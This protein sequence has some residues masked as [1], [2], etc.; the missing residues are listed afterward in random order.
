MEIIEQASNE[1]IF[2]REIYW[3]AYHRSIG[4][5]LTNNSDGGEGPIGY[6]HTEETVQKMREN[7]RSNPDNVK[8][9][10]SPESRRKA[11]LT[12]T[13]RHDSDQVR[14][15][16]SAGKMGIKASE[17]AKQHQ[18]AAAIKKYQTETGIEQRLTYGRNYA[19]LTDDQ[20]VEMRRLFR[21]TKLTHREISE[22][23]N[24]ALSTVS[25]IRHGKRYMHVK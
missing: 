6:K 4:T 22:M 21:E 5:R 10:H 9:L 16:K 14:R 25:H 24:I 20:V 19:K 2:E 8:R 1:V 12:R 18:S 11:S 17:S 7:A 13:G 15:N 23:F 3:I